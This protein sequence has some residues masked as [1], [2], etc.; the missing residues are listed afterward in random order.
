MGEDALFTLQLRY[1]LHSV[2]GRAKCPTDAASVPQCHE[3]VIGSLH[4][5]LDKAVYE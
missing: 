3:L 1:Q 2:L 5:L 4:A